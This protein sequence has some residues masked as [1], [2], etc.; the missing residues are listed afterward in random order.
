VSALVQHPGET[1]QERGTKGLVR[2]V[3][4]FLVWDVLGPISSKWVVGRFRR[5]AKGAGTVE[6]A[7]DL[8]MAFRSL[9]VQIT[10]LQDREEIIEFLKI[11]ERMRPRNV[12][13]IGTAR[14][15]TLFLLT[16]VASEDA[17]LTSLDLPGG[18]FGGGYPERMVPLL[19]SFAV[20]RQRI[21]LMKADS[22]SEHTR[23]M[24]EEVMGGQKLDLLFIDGDHTYDG[25]RRDF[26][27][28]SP[29]VRKGGIIAFHDICP[30]PEDKVGGVPRFWAEVSVG[31]DSKS[32]IRDPKQGGFGI[33]MLYW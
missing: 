1:S 21:H 6:A 31:R 14:G 2:A 28:Y 30:G 11:V 23:R 17:V 12:L 27:M 16:R 3:L 29:L 13:E 33:G 7:V 32:V 18:P 9:H 10:P 4:R 26:E 22:H 24:V 19:E 5:S 20:E 25:V 8:A 15:G